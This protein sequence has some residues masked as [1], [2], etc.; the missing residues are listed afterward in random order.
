[1]AR[2][3]SEER[4]QV[5]RGIGHAAGLALATE[6]VGTFGCAATPEPLAMPLS[7]FPEGLRVRV[8]WAGRPVEVIRNGAN[9]SARS[10]V[11][12]HERCEVRWEAHTRRY[13]CPCHGGVF[14]PDGKAI[15]GPPRDPLP[16]VPVRISGEML[17]LGE[18]EEVRSSLGARVP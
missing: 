10:L 2:G 7:Q 12:T 16:A 14:D 17:V 9:V 11:C 1:M 15:S 8:A 13:V 6:V 3:T 18:G 4:R 5:L